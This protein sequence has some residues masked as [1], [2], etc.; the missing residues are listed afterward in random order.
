MLTAVALEFTNHCNLKC[1]FCPSQS[2][3]LHKPRVKGFMSEALLDKVLADLQRNYDCS[4]IVAAV[5]YGGEST[6]H[7]KFAE[8][9]E[10]VASAGF[11]VVHFY[12]N[13][14]LLNEANCKVLADNDVRVYVSLH[15]HGL[16][17]Q[18]KQNTV[19]LKKQLK[20]VSIS[21]LLEEWTRREASE[22]TK[23]AQQN[24]MSITKC[25]GITENL[26]LISRPANVN[27]RCMSMDYYLGVLWNGDCVPCCHM[28]STD[29]FSLG[30]VMHRT[31]SEVFNGGVY[32]KLRNH[33]WQ[34]TPC[35]WCEIKS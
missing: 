30:N 10:K 4:R 17:E 33:D 24:F 1:W 12:T 20:Q 28:L 23:F 26:H 34:D 6:L 19:A 15:R 25:S 16:L 11:Y 18:V 7:P 31:I 29:G 14:I 8:Y 3:R 27:R 35:E 22:L 21:I 32:G 9:I 13:G 2:P 5:S